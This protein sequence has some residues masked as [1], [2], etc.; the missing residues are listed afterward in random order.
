LFFSFFTVLYN[1][2]FWEKNKIHPSLPSL[3]S[4]IQHLYKISEI[5]KLQF[6]FGF[7]LELENKQDQILAKAEICRTCFS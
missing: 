4:S 6:E 3:G 2:N 1:W 5:E 7:E